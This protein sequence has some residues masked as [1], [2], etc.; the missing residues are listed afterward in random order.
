MKLIDRPKYLEQLKMWQSQPDLVKIIT[1][2]RR[3][4]KSVL[5]TI[6]QNDLRANGTSDEQIININL[7]NETQTKQIGLKLNNKTKLLEE[8]GILL[9][10][11]TDKLSKDKKTYVFLDEIQLLDNWQRLANTLRLNNDV[12]VYLTGSNAHMFSSDLANAFG[13]RYIE[14]RMYPLSFKEY[15][16][17]QNAQFTS[18]DNHNK[19]LDNLTRQVALTDAYHKYISQGGFPQTVAFN[20]NRQMISDYLLDSVYKNTI[21]KDV[22][23]RFG[24]SDPVRLD[25][26]VKFMFDNIGNETSLLNVQ[27]K[28]KSAG[29]DISPTTLN[30]YVKGLLDSYLMYKCER[31][32]LKGKRILESDSKY[33]VADI[34]LRTALLGRSDIDLGH[35]LENVVYLELV[36]RGYDVRTGKVKTRSTK[37]GDK[38]EPKTIEIDF[39][40]TK[41]G[42][43]AEYY[44]VAWSVLG[45]N[46]TLRRELA[47]LEE[48]KDN[49]PKYLLTMDYGEGENNGIKRINVLDWLS[50]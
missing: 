17:S 33:Y 13:G 44:Q 21:Q 39:V 46:S 28:L 31:Y 4:G 43:K 24:I 11:I 30:S 2:V 32:D 36:R 12:D 14:I 34:G 5:F 23:Q 42:G 9:D 40:A 25:E 35:T 8:Y 1:G 18:S 41:A 15:F 20:N 7:E 48:V 50:D 37:V 38:T 29:I 10:F 26:I 47:S 45:D 49:Y 19:E 3:C 27:K 6:F 16:S 22:I